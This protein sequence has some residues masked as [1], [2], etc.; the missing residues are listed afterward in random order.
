VLIEALAAIGIA[1]VLAGGQEPAP[2][3]GAKPEE[4]KQT[5]QAPKAGT[6]A[7]DEIVDPEQAADTGKRGFH[8]EWKQHPSIRYGSV[9]RLDFQAKL[10]EDGHWSYP[11]ALGLNCADTALPKRCAWELHRNRVG[12]QGHVFKRIEY[13]VERELT[14]QELTER[15]L[16]AG[17]T[18]KSVWKDVDVNISSIDNAQVQVGKFKIPFG[19]DELTGDSHNDFAYRSLGANYLSP[20][21]DIGVMV[22]GR[23][24]KRGL[25]YWTGVFRHDGDNARS[26]KI[27]GG[28]ET[29]AARVSA[30]PFRRLSPTA[31]GAFEIGTAYAIS[32]V[33]DDSLLPNGLRGRTTLTQDTF[34]EPVYVNGRRHRWEADLDWTIGPASTRAEYIRTT[35]DRLQQGLGDQDLP[36][37]RSQSWYASATW[38]LTGEKK[39]RPVKAA[40]EFLTAGFGAVE[41]GARYERLWFDSVGTTGTGV[42]LRNPRAE[43]IFPSGVRALTIGVN[44]TLNRW[45]KLQINGIRQDVEDVELNSAAISGA[46]WSRVVRLQIV[47]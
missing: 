25:S 24:F 12:I 10:Q 19:L 37:A 1:A 4:P 30:T 43:N 9:F 36:D 26:K 15:E 32:K 41:V 27:V 16:L 14:E 7:P 21:R 47:L 20:S 22:H 39:A 42:A 44:W 6:L 3:T 8:V 34:Y 46:F 28:D 35:D 2:S 18:A 29:I 11:G 33:S 31:L 5:Q 17:Y 23:F 13:E 38:I 40:S 45:L